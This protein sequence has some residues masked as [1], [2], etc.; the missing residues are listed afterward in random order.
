VVGGPRPTRQSSRERV[1]T[2]KAR[3]LKMR[4]LRMDSSDIEDA[5]EVIDTVPAAPQP[6]WI[7]I[8]AHLRGRITTT[9]VQ[10]LPAKA[11]RSAATT[12]NYLSQEKGATNAQ[13]KALTA[14]SSR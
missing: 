3:E 1:Q 8:S 4:Q 13:I 2:P 10:V 5:V 9:K 12:S 6:K 14:L 11:D 7:E